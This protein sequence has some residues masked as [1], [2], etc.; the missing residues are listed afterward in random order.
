MKR[1]AVFLGFLFTYGCGQNVSNV[2]A[3]KD[4]FFRGMYCAARPK[5]DGSLFVSCLD[6]AK[7]NILPQQAPIFLDCGKW[8]EVI[9]IDLYRGSYIPFR[10]RYSEFG[11]D[12]R[13]R[14]MPFYNCET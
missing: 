12:L 11:Y 8:R 3:P 5:W 1:L 7:L 2:P 9:Y 14:P 10:F 13:Y 6:G 4:Q